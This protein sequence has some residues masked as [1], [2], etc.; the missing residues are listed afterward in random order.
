[1]ARTRKKSAKKEQTKSWPPRGLVMLIRLALVVIVAGFLVFYLWKPSKP[2][3]KT[4]PPPP[5]LEIAQNFID[6]NAPFVSQKLDISFNGIKAVRGYTGWGEKPLKNQGIMG[7][8]LNINGKTYERGIGTQAPS[9]IIFDLKGNVKK[10]SCLA[11]A[12]NK[13]GNS[14]M[15]VFAVKADGKKLYQSP[16][17]KIQDEPVSIDVDVTG[18]KELSLIV[19]PYGDDSWKQAIWANPKFTKISGSSDEADQEAAAPEK[20]SPPA[21]KKKR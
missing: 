8:E 15:I 13:G 3:A 14:D 1:M 2:V 4:P 11:G 16:M 9:V 7:G 21:K 17:M 6:S 18:A 10:F 12:D 5:P 20:K 19:A